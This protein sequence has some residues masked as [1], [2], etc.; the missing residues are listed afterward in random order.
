VVGQ[1]GRVAGTVGRAVDP[2]N[3]A[4][5]VAGGVGKGVGHV[6]AAIGGVTTGVGGQALRTAAR[7]GFEGG[8][9]AKAFR[10]NMRGT[11]PMENVVSDA[12]VGLD[13][14]KQERQAA[15]RAGMADLAKDQTVLDFGKVDATLAGAKLRV[16]G[17]RA[18]P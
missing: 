11:V 18:E 1:I 4:L 10:E 7:T 13:A 5:K 14:I 12:K 3:A 6:G 8:E 15:Y 9:A 17:A 2:I 16:A